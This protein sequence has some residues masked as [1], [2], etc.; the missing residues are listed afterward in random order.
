MPSSGDCAAE[1]LP[2]RDDE[3]GGVGGDCA[4]GD[5]SAATALRVGARGEVGRDR[6]RTA[7]AVHTG[8]SLE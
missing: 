5:S 7:E 6:D 1:G 2:P 4:T 8:Q 3:V